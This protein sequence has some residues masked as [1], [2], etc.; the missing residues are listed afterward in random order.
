V[1]RFH[2]N[3]ILNERHYDGYGRAGGKEVTSNE[4][5]Q[6]SVGLKTVWT[7]FKS[8]IRGLVEFGRV[9]LS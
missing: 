3:A 1:L 8:C 5:S 7:C 6:W 2:S 9:L 4:L